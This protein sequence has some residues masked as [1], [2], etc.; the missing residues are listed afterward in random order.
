MP[1]ACATGSG[2]AARV[3]K[4]L[5]AEAAAQA[6][7][8]R[9]TELQRV[10]AGDPTAMRGFL[11]RL[12]REEG[13]G[14]I[15]T[16]DQTRWFARVARREVSIP[17]PIDHAAFAIGLHEI[18]HC[19]VGPCAG[20]ALECERLAWEKAGTLVAFSREMFEQLRQSLSTYRRGT[21]APLAV[22][23]QADRQMGLV[24]WGQEYQKRLRWQWMLERQ[25]LAKRRIG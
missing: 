18:G 14:L 5:A 6:A 3:K 2:L 25:A 10:E 1:G 13:I 9:E 22:Q 17:P 7:R 21:P 20:P 24:T 23:Q 11:G 19:L 16:A 12:C 8:A 15:W 4:E